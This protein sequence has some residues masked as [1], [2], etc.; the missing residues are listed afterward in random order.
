MEFDIWEEDIFSA[1]L[2]YCLEDLNLHLIKINVNYLSSKIHWMDINFKKRLLKIITKTLTDLKK[3]KSNDI[4]EILRI[5]SVEN[6]CKK[7]IKEL[8]GK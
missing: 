8:R 5:N 4:L 2:Q 3:E 1:G 7:L 6:L